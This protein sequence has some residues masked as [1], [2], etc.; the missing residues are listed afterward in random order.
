M[1]ADYQQKCRVRYICMEGSLKIFS[2]KSKQIEEEIK[3]CFN[4]QQIETWIDFYYHQDWLCTKTPVPDGCD[5]AKISHREIKIPF[6]LVKQM[7]GKTHAH[8][9]MN[10][11]V[12]RTCLNLKN[13]T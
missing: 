4:N 11:E 12:L 8:Y 5:I 10:E 1:I 3:K 7:S 13:H 9:F 6:S 2:I